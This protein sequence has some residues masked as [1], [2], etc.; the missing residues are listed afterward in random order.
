MAGVVTHMLGRGPGTG[1]IPFSAVKLLIGFE[2][3][4]ASTTF[5]DE[6]S[7][8]L[9]LTPSGNAQIDTAQF[10][11][12]SSSGLFDGTGDFLTQSN[13]SDFSLGTTSVDVCCE[14]WVRISSTGRIHTIAGKRSAAGATEWT[15]SVTAAN[16]L[17]FALFNT[18]VVGLAVGATTLTTGAWYHAAAVRYTSGGTTNVYVFLDG[19]LD[20]SG[21]QTSAA[22]TNST[23]FVVGRDTSNTGRDFA[24]W[25]DE[26]RFT[27]GYARY[28]A[29]FT[30]PTAAFPRS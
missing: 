28:T 5:T 1:G 20:G 30:P 11:F 29:N 9:S 26:F 18:S 10:K 22:Q 3:A 23:S 6:S 7:G 14:A 25:I 2:G 15:F 27:R 13:N 8:A 21:T 16:V 24:G 4:D 17:Q 12:G 19:V